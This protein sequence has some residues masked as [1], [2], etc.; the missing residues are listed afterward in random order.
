MGRAGRNLVPVLSADTEDSSL[1][2]VSPGRAFPSVQPHGEAAASGGA[3]LLGSRWAGPSE[4]SGRFRGAET[5]SLHVS[6]YPDARRRVTTAPVSHSCPGGFASPVWPEPLAR[7]RTFSC[8]GAGCEGCSVTVTLQA[9]KA[10]T[11]G[12][13]GRQPGRSC[14]PCSPCD[15]GPIP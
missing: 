12:E 14:W 10:R 15:A 4:D 2:P 8:P 9:V 7:R 11:R 1:A 3:A 13:G 6:F 5:P